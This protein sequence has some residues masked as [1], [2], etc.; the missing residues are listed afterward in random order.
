MGPHQND[1][2]LHSKKTIFF[3]F[4]YFFIFFVFLGPH[5]HHME[6]SSLGV[7]SELEL[8]A[9]TTAIALPDLSHI[10]DLHH[11]SQQRQIPN[12]LSKATDRTRILMDASQ[13][14]S[15]EP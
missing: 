2:L 6:V 4:F 12:P 10:C 3:K 15:A 11:S 1:K 13:I 14:V 8:L 5:L 7:E 9:Y